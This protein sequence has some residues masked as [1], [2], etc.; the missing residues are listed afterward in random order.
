MH[1]EK[2]GRGEKEQEA[3][4][5]YLAAKEILTMKRTNVQ[6]YKQ[7]KHMERVM[8]SSYKLIDQLRAELTG[9][10]TTFKIAF[11]VGGKTKGQIYEASVSL[12]DILDMSHLESVYRNTS[13]ASSMKLRLRANA[14]QKKSWVSKYGADN[15]TEQYR[16]FMQGF[17]NTGRQYEFYRKA[18]IAGISDASALQKLKDSIS[19]DTTSF[20]K[21]VDF[22]Y[23]KDGQQYFE[24][25]KSFIGG[26]PS[27]ASLS[28]VLTTLQ[29]L[30]TALSN[31]QNIQQYFE[32][33]L[34]Q[35][36][37]QQ[38]IEQAVKN[39]IEASIPEEVIEPLLSQIFPAEQI[40]SLFTL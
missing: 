38:G 30:S 13:A 27:L 33:Q 22:A 10:Q 21:G 3:Y 32:A 28:T 36:Q 15:I 7:V 26:A 11:D 19:S 8:K 24:S 6:Q 16:S 9:Q 20:V 2:K 1:I 29:T 17:S 12:A 14:A 31:P 5:R 39:T 25:L 40:G 37:H 34:Q 4:S 35:P 23:S 18:T